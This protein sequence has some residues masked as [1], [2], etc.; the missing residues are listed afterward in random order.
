MGDYIVNTARE[1]QQM[2]QAIG[3]EKPSD[4]FNG[5]PEDV[6]LSGPLDLPAGKSEAE[7]LSLI[8]D[9]ADKN[10][11]FRTCFRGA[12]AY[13]HYI[14]AIVKNVTAKDEFKTAYTP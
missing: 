7:V 8:E 3:V 2:C 10:Q 14:P 4:L 1:Q 11:V 5:L 9:M 13:R 12:G 6:R